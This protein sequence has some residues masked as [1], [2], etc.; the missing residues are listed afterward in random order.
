MRATVVAFTL[1]ELLVVIGVIAIL[2]GAMGLGLSGGSRTTDL[3]SARE[4]L[5]VQLVAA[6]SQA[7]L[8]Q[9]EAA[10]FIAA[11]PTD[12]SYYLRYLTVVA[13]ESASSPWRVSSS[14]ATLPGE[15]W[16]M[17]PVS[18][19][20]LLTVTTSIEVTPG[21]AATLGYLLLINANGTL[22]NGGAGELWVSSGTREENQVRFDQT[23]PRL[24]LTLSRYGAIS[25]IDDNREGAP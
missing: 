18:G 17:P 21:Q 1:I 13:R 22:T 4:I 25:L 7:A 2:V 12:D 5:R 20:T 16:V 8:H 15:V 23:S 24:G 3:A 10:L 9:Q 19:S 11:D 6:R 14:G